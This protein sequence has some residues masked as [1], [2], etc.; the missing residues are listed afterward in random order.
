MARAPLYRLLDVQVEGPALWDRRAPH[1]TPCVRS[2]TYRHEPSGRVVRIHRRRGYGFS[3]LRKA[4]FGELGVFFYRG[5]SMGEGGSGNLW[6]LREH[7]REVLRC[8]PAGGL[9]VT[10]GSQ[11]GRAERGEYDS[12]WRYRDLKVEDVQALLQSAEPFADGAGRQFR[13]VG[14]AGRRYGRTLAWQRLT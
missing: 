3:A 12:F 5:D 2:E 13:C 4:V 9:F 7:V 10:D 14:Y 6:L 8:L 11:H 1:I